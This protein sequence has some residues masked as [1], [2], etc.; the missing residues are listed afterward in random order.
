MNNINTL[1]ISGIIRNIP[2]VDGKGNFEC[3]GTKYF[4]PGSKI[5]VLPP[6][7]SYD[8]CR[9]RFKVIGYHKVDGRIANIWFN[10]LRAHK[11]ALEQLTD[12]ELLK[13]HGDGWNREHA[14]GMLKYLLNCD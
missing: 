12:L 1:T 9:G 4:S 11:W 10:H 5:Y 8:M 14:E 13:Y 7:P 3:Q 2:K 6:I